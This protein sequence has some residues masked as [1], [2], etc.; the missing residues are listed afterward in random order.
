M[1]RQG[2]ANVSTMRK[3]FAIAR[4][5]ASSDRDTSSGIA[6]AASPLALHF[7]SFHLEVFVARQLA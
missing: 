7:L 1:L 4:L 2:D 6:L 3:T 5:S